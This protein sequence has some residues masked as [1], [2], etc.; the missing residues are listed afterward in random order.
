[1]KGA[2]PA[3]QEKQ[4]HSLRQVEVLFISNLCW[5][6]L[7]WVGD[8]YLIISS[9][10]QSAAL[11]STPTHIY[12]CK[13]GHVHSDRHILVKRRSDNVGYMGVGRGGAGRGRA[14]P[15]EFEIFSKK[16]C[17][18]SFEWEKANFT[19]SAPPQKNFWKHSLVALPGKNPSDAHGWS[20]KQ[21]WIQGKAHEDFPSSTPSFPMPLP[22]YNAG[23]FIFIIISCQ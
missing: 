14:P 9:L 1:M 18:L 13:R 8:C 22:P 15:L 3:F 17:F 4:Y 12:R 16:C 5:S 7:V 21:W 20:W 11:S 19:I 2:F 10:V 6:F 23:H